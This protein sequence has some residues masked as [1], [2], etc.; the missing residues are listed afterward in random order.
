MKCVKEW[1][2]IEQHEACL[3]LPHISSQ[4]LLR[5]IGLMSVSLTQEKWQGTFRHQ[6]KKE[7]A[8]SIR[9]GLNLIWNNIC[10]RA[11]KFGTWKSVECL[12]KTIRP[13]F[14]ANMMHGRTADLSWLCV[15]VFSVKIE[16]TLKQNL[17]IIYHEL[18]ELKS[19]YY[20]IS[21]YNS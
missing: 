6:M 20:W 4:T 1:T 14:L 3:M 9:N 19:T 13:L 11:W 16:R 12:E 8:D 18:W 21:D 2:Y 5:R 7:A 10:A 15:T 17:R